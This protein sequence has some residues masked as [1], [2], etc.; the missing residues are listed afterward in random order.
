MRSRGFKAGGAGVAGVVGV[1]G[2]EKL[3]SQ[4]AT[5]IRR[6]QPEYPLSIAML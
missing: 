4:L 1:V 2:G 3:R 6:S 5:K